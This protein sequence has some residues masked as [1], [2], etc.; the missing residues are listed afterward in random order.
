MRGR[1]ALALGL[2]IGLASVAVQAQPAGCLTDPSGRTHEEV[3]S[4]LNASAEVVMAGAVLRVAPVIEDGA[5]RTFVFMESRRIWRGFV[6]QY[7]RF[8]LDGCAELYQSGVSYLLFLDRDPRAPKGEYRL[9]SGSY[10][11][12]FKV[13]DHED[14][15]DELGDPQVR[16]KS[17]RREGP[18]LVPGP[19]DGYVALPVAA[20]P[21]GTAAPVPAATVPA[22]ELQKKVLS[23]DCPPAPRGERG[24]CVEAIPAYPP[25]AAAG[26]VAGR[27]IANVNVEASGDVLFVNVVEEDP[28]DQGFATRAVE[29]L[30]QTRFQPAMGDKGSVPIEVRRETVIFEPAN[31]SDGGR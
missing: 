8:P 29:A 5:E 15:V 16:W 22:P 24:R 14:L 9:A 3:A 31:C 26:C 30:L 11:R 12:P 2:G 18:D 21:V 17:G 7:F 25:A 13:A 6:P 28:V 10:A 23:A 19:A 4:Q 20:G 27:V 1:I